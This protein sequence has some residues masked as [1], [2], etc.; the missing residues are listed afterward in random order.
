MTDDV[1]AGDSDDDQPTTPQELVEKHGRDRLE[2][3][4]E[5]GNITAGVVLDIVDEEGQR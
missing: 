2:D 3:L 1:E 4:A 5:D